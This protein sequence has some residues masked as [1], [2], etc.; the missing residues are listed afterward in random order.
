M[1]LYKEDAF[2]EGG[3]AIC[4]HFILVLLTLGYMPFTLTSRNYLLFFDIFLPGY[5]QL[6]KEYVLETTIIKIKGIAREII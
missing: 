5:C 6:N 1:V 4:S 3:S 2:W